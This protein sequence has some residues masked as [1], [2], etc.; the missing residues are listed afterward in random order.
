MP[1]IRLCTIE[2]RAINSTAQL[3]FL[4]G[5]TFK[6][7]KNKKRLIRSNIWSNKLDRSHQVVFF[8]TMK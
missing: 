4:N 5:N 3:H 7:K 2:L 8:P 1:I 6:K